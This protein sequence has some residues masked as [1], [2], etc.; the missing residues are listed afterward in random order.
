MSICCLV[1]SV[2]CQRLCR[3]VLRR[4]AR[5]RWRSESAWGKLQLPLKCTINC[6]KLVSIHT[7]THT[8]ITCIISLI[9][10]TVILLHH[11]CLYNSIP[12]GTVISMETSHDLLDLICFYCDRNP[13]QEWEPQTED[14][15]GHLR[16]NPHVD[17]IKWFRALLQ[18]RKRYSLKSLFT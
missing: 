12:P 15:V 16:F 18:Q 14:M 11:L 10:V 2:W 3:F 17:T 5:R 13:A 7:H 6:C 1:C 4:W 9:A 8:S